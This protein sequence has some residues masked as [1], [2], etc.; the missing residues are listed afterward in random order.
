MWIKRAGHSKI[1][2][3]VN[4]FGWLAPWLEANRLVWLFG[5]QAEGEVERKSY[6]GKCPGYMV[7]LI[8]TRN[9]CGMKYSR[10]FSWRANGS[11]KSNKN[12]VVRIEWRSVYGKS[13][14]FFAV[15]NPQLLTLQY[16]HLQKA[17]QTTH[18]R[19]WTLQELRKFF[20]ADL[21]VKHLPGKFT[22]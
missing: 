22:I 12:I 5:I 8:V 11:E 17:E 21:I 15:C 14:D 7:K 9:I 4:F 16:P 1:T 2:V 6:E 10:M 19:F 13:W 18:P 3:A 20:F